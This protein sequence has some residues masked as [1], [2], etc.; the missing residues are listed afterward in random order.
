MQIDERQYWRVLCERCGAE[1]EQWRSYDGDSFEVKCEC[2]QKLTV[3]LTKGPDGPSVH[4]AIDRSR[5][6]SSRCRFF[7]KG[8]RRLPTIFRGLD[9]RTMFRVVWKADDI[10]ILWIL[11]ASPSRYQIAR[12][13][14]HADRFEIITQ[15]TCTSFEQAYELAFDRPFGASSPSLEGG[16]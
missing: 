14:E 10:Y 15:A 7:A 13:E 11:D 16:A 8:N 2:T 4:I 6:R 12:V 5:F 1:Q 3:G 9:P